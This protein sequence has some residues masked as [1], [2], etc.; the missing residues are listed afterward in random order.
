[1]QRI[2]EDGGAT[3]LARLVEELPRLFDV[4]ESSVR[5]YAGTPQFV[6]RDGYVSLADPSTL[7]FRDLD[8][9]IDGRDETDGSPYW[10]FIVDDR[11]FAGY[12]VLGLPPE[13]ARELGCEPNTSI[14]VPLKAPTGC[15]DLSI[16]W[17]LAS[18]TGATLGY[19]A[20][21]LR[22][23]QVEAGDV[24]RLVLAA[25]GVRLDREWPAKPTAT[26]GS[27]HADELLERLKR[28]RRV[29]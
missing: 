10:S 19:L 16:N 14:R 17:R 9:V 25:D 8:D 7:S 20:D 13:L 28:R 27:T 2:E 5:T 11:Y 29:L 15:R 12:S 3:S 6:L 18:S 22:R 24:V 4:S 26:V 23:L 21:P 1:M